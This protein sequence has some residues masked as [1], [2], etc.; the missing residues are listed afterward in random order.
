MA[1]FTNGTLFCA[2]GWGILQAAFSTV[3]RGLSSLHQSFLVLKWGRI[4][5]G[6]YLKGVLQKVFPDGRL[7]LSSTQGHSPKLTR[8]TAGSDKAGGGGVSSALIRDILRPA[9]K[10]QHF[11]KHSD[12]EENKNLSEM[13]DQPSLNTDVINR[14]SS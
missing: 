12:L 13:C 10:L 7:C 4:L 5:Q 14:G 9:R 1:V 3:S 11:S 2:S 8:R 6:E